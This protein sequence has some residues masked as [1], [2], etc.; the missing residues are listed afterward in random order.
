MHLSVDREPRP[1]REHKVELLVT[2]LGL[3]VTRLRL[4]GVRLDDI[5]AGLAGGVGVAPERADSERRADR[6]P[7]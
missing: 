4:L 7:G 2:C 6:T 1:P 5:L 3:R